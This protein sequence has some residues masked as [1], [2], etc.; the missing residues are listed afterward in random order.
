MYIN[1]FGGES[2]NIATPTISYVSLEE[3]ETWLKTGFLISR[4]I[5]PLAS[6]NGFF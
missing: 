4:V 2:L 3:Y 6:A 5:I 1:R